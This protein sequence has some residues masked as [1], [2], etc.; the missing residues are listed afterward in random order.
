MVFRYGLDLTECNSGIEGLRSFQSVHAHDSAFWDPFSLASCPNETHFLKI[1]IHSMQ[2]CRA[3][4]RHAITRKRSKKILKHTEN[5]F[6]KNLPS[7]YSS[8]RA[9]PQNWNDWTNHQMA[10]C[11]CGRPNWIR[12]GKL[13]ILGYFFV[14]L[15]SDLVNLGWEYLNFS[16]VPNTER[17]M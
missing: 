15:V 11:I 13:N 7:V 6:R 8:L 3:I 10:F 5:L 4:A 14:F 17:D 2:D 9:I 1:G 16:N 12:D